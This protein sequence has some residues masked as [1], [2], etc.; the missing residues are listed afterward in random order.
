MHED[1][2][3]DIPDERE[4]AVILGCVHLI[5]DF[6]VLFMVRKIINILTISKFV[7]KKYSFV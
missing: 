7:M 1:I 5:Q 6:L 2:I 3:C 4:Q